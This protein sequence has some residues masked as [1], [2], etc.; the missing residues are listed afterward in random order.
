VRPSIRI[1]GTAITAATVIA[2][3][4]VGKVAELDAAMGDDAL[5]LTR[6]AGGA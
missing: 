6:M 4:D 5:V 2:A 3:A 1:Y